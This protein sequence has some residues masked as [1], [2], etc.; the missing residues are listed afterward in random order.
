MGGPD[1]AQNR[2][3][4][5]RFTGKCS[6]KRVADWKSGDWSFEA[7]PHRT[8]KTED[9]R[10]SSG[11]RRPQTEGRGLMAGKRRTGPS[12]WTKGP[13]SGRRPDAFAVEAGFD[14]LRVDLEDGPARSQRSRDGGRD[15]LNQFG[16]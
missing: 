7:G 11:G 3:R 14:D 15:W 12:F 5:R 13:A 8:P 2:A 1:I 4:V 9:R 6:K 16:K 10:P